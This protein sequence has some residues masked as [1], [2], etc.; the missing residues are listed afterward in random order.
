MFEMFAPIGSH[1][2]ENKTKQQQKKKHN[3]GP[4]SFDVLLFGSN[5]SI[6][7]IVMYDQ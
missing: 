1:T 6:N 2:N 3:N 7:C 5:N 4:I